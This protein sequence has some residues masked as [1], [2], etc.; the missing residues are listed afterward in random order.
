MTKGAIGQLTKSTAID[1]APFSIRLNCICPG[2]IQTPLL[3]NAVQQFVAKSGQ[4]SSAV[5]SS[6]DTAQPIGRIGQPE[7]IAKAVRFLL[8]ET[9]LL[10]YRL[11]FFSRWWIYISI[12]VKIYQ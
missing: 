1:Y 2:T 5:Y 4:D 3:D 8:L 7:E 11:P 6:L 9:I 10:Y 12:K